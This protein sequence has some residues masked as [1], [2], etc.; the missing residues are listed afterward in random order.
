MKIRTIR[1]LRKYRSRPNLIGDTADFE[2]VLADYEGDPA[3]S[4]GV[5]A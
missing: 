1:P 4:K 2:G 5:L 3:D